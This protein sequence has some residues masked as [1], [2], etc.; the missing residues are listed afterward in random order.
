MNA[1]LAEPL[2]QCP[3]G[4]PRDD[5]DDIAL[6]IVEDEPVRCA[7][8]M[9]DLTMALEAANMVISAAKQQVFGLTKT[10]RD[11]WKARGGTVVALAKDSGISRDG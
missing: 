2:W 5:V 1:F 3:T 7:A 4:Q 8:Q 9:G 11:A 6:H 10:V